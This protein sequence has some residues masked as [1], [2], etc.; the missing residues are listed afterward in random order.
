MSH[1]PLKKRRFSEPKTTSAKVKRIDVISAHEMFT[2]VK[3]HYNAGIKFYQKREYSL[4]LSE[5]KK[6]LALDA[7]HSGAR[8]YM[9]KILLRMN[10]VE[11]DSSY[12][13]RVKE[14]ASKLWNDEEKKWKEEVQLHY[15]NG[16]D[17]YDKKDYERSIAEFERVLM[18]DPAHKEAGLRLEQAQREMGR[19]EKLV[20]EVIN[21]TKE[22]EQ[23]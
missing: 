16:I 23:E 21:Q 17:C 10:R 6:V 8:G 14:E 12:R 2:K 4:A 11:E 1:P 7:T 3:E 19:I 5:M 9:E 13:I 22:R 18:L 20:D 15:Q